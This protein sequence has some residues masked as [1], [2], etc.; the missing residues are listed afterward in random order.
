MS[1]LGEKGH[2]PREHRSIHITN[3]ECL[4]LLSLDGQT[5]HPKTANAMTLKNMPG[6]PK[7]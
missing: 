5:A 7:K 6:M 1:V 4:R 2:K 3:D